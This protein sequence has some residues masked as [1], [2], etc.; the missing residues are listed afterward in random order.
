MVTEPRIYLDNAATSWPKPPEV[1]QAVQYALCQLGA[2]AGRGTYA[3]GI[4]VDRVL[5]RTRGLLA[6]LLGR[7]DPQRVIF[8][9][10]GTDSLNLALHG[11]LQPGDH[12]VTT[13]AEHNSVL[14]PVRHLEQQ[15]QITV[16]RVGCDSSGWVD[17]DEI[18]RALRRP[19]RLVALVH[20]SN[21]TGVIQS[22]EIVGRLAH[23]AGALFLLDAAQTLG[24]IPVD[25]QELSV[26]LLAASGHKSLLGPLGTGV[27]YVAPG[28]EQQLLSVRQGGTGSRSDEDHQPDSLPDKYESGN[29]NVP[30]LFGLAA[31]LEYLQTRGLQNI[32][33]HEL[34]LVDQLLT[35]L[36]AI[37]GVT[38]YGPTQA[39]QRCGVVSLNVEGFDPR[40]LAALLDS[41]RRIQTRAGLHCA[42][43][44]HQALGTAPGGGTLRLSVGPFNTPEQMATVATCF[45]ELVGAPAP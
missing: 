11:L 38:L 13:V 23:E 2:P 14:R 35:D 44:I 28:V 39:D 43:L 21:V 32:R 31:G 18:A 27:L 30:A 29:L 5:R 36:A 42:P 8:T 20:A 40:E 9:F 15:H 6:E 37:A 24:H 1:Y 19:T 22:A 7:V 34:L 4:E 17:P 16:T 45:R 12:L 26:D 25:V 10:N 41:A 3:E 33:Q